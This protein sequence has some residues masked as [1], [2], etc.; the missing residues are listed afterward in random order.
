MAL[1]NPRS[2]VLEMPLLPRLG[3]NYRFGA[4]IESTPYLFDVRWNSRDAAWYMDVLEASEQ[5]IVLGIKLVL[6]AYLG[7][8]SNHRLFKRGVFMMLDTSDAGR[9]ATYDDLGERVILVYMPIDELIRRLGSY[10]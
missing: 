5:P 8:R 7:R 10:W 1:T 2:P 6:G 3:G 4:T 9:D